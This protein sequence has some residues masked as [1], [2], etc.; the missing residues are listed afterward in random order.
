[1]TLQRRT[2]MA[3]AAAS[4]VLVLLPLPAAAISLDDEVQ[5]ALDAI[6]DGRSAEEGGIALDTPAVAE[7]GAQVPLTVRVD[8]PMTAEDHVSAI[9]I[10]ATANPEPGIGSFHLTPHLTKAEVFTRIRLAEEQDFLV[11]AELSDGRVLQAAARTAV[12]I[13]GCAT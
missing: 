7:N 1:M 5:A 6:L 12:S 2:F 11:L 9:H 10:I 3:S 13:G 4:A 8:S